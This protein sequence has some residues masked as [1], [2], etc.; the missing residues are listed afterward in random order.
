MNGEIDDGEVECRFHRYWN[1]SSASYGLHFSIRSFDYGRRFLFQGHENAGD[2]AY[3]TRVNLDVIDPSHRVTLLTPVGADGKTHFNSIDG[4]T[5]DPFTR[6]L[7]FTQEDGGATLQLPVTWPPRLTS[8]AGILGSG[9]YEGVQVDSDG[10]LYL[11]EDIAGTRV[12]V[13]RAMRPGR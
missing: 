12:N 9:G 1:S 4:S 6:T 5:Y 2:L 7:L 8:L 3:I 13:Y 11:A 10:D